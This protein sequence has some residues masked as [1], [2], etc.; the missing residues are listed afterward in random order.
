MPCV[1]VASQR[2]SAF[3]WWRPFQL[4]FSWWWNGIKSP[5]LKT[6]Q[7]C[8][9]AGLGW[10][11]TTVVPLPVLPPHRRTAWAWSNS[12]MIR[13]WKEEA[14]KAANE[15]PAGRLVAVEKTE[16]PLNPN[17]VRRLLFY[18]TLSGASAV[19]SLL[20]GNSSAGGMA[21]S[22]KDAIGW[23]YAVAASPL[24]NLFAMPPMSIVSIRM[25]SK[26]L[27]GRTRYTQQGLFNHVW[28]WS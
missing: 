25:S 19:A 7:S 15:C 3:L 14:I 17:M 9:V 20:R 16:P 13:F 21:A 5:I 10:W 23:F 6:G 24:T 2:E 1:A 4:W 26:E 8:S 22:T 12:R 11:M 27:T 28:V 18:R